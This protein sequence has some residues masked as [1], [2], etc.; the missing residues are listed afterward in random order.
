MKQYRYNEPPIRLFGAPL[1]GTETPFYRI[2]AE[3][4]ENVRRTLAE[5]G[6]RCPGARIGFRT[7][8]RRF[9]VRVVLESMRFDVGMSVFEAQS[10]E[11]LIG[12]RRAP[13]FG[14]L[15]FPPDYGTTEFSGEF[16]K[17]AETEDILILLPRNEPVRDVII[18]VEDDAIVEPPTPYDGKPIIFYGSSITEGGCAA[19]MNSYNSIISNRLN[20]DYYNFG[21]SGNCRGDLVL[22]DYFAGIDTSL[23]V[24]DYDHNADSAE[25]LAATHEPFYKRYRALRPDVPVLFMSMP[26][27]RYE[28]FNLPR[29]E[30]IR[31]TYENALAAGEPV[32]FLDGEKFFGER[33]RYLC[34][35]DCTH[36]NALGF[37]RMAE[38]VG[39]MISEILG[40]PSRS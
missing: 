17:S 10:V 24:F 35:I 5:L 40:I 38:V 16:T 20:V 23:F 6:C 39:D 32:F 26:R 30:I 3:I 33:D 14:G 34:T 11:V 8:S 4:R 28:E 12:D 31:K 29:R 19:M 21:F 36:P 2:P 37:Y 15:C 25:M 13:R 22:A 18:T 7:N 1:A 9:G 27:E